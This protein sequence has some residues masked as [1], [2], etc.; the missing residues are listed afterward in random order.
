[1]A[2]NARGRD[3]MEGGQM[4]GQ[5][6]RRGLIAGVAALAAAGLA[7]LAGAGRA[8]ASH[9][10]TTTYTPDNTMHVDVINTTLG[11]TSVLSSISGGNPALA[12]VNNNPATS[13]GAIGGI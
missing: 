1:M 12:G 8:E 10:S 9:D 11:T 7:K 3:E 4:V 2:E 13:P 6:R 5:L